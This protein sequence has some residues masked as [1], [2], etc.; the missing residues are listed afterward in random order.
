MK[1]YMAGAVSG[2]LIKKWQ[3]F[4]KIYIAQLGNEKNRL[5]DTIEKLKFPSDSNG[6]GIELRDLNILESYHYISRIEWML[7]MISDLNGFLLDSGAFTYINSNPKKLNWEEYV[8]NYGRFV[9]EHGI[10]NFFELDIDPIVGIKEVER[11][12]SILEEEAGRKCIPVWHK[13]R[14]L[15]YW[16]KMIR[17]YEYVAIG[18]IVTKEIRKEQYDVF[19]PLLK[20]ARSEGTRVHGLGFTSLEGLKKYPFYSVDSTAWLSGNKFGAVYQFT[21]DSL[22]KQKKEKGQKVKNIQTATQN[23]IEWAKF[24]KYAETN[25]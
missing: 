13:S 23:F 20:M 12:R 15:D 2:N 11:L 21:G 18:G 16:K 9:R 25:L 7:P 24:G 17:D 8:R 10:L 19:I 14:G 22:I 1:I 6:I 4:M 5:A 3:E